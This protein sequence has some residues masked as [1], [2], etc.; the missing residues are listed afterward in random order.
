M[1]TLT[2]SVLGL[3]LQALTLLAIGVGAW[4]LISNS[5]LMH[6]QFESMYVERY[7]QVMD[8]RSESWVLKG[9]FTKADQVVARQYLL[10]CEDEIDLRR[11][12][13]VSDSTWA[14]WGEAI[15]DQATLEPYVSA[16]DK[17][18]YPRLEQFLAEGNDPLRHSVIWRKRHGL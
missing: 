7:W 12:G 17:S 9:V 6:R 5:R 16:L 10:V 18:G 13:R 3:A 11:L 15:R 1:P 8:R 4:Q 2:L 14:F